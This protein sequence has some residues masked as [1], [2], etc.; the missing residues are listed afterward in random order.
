[1]TLDELNLMFKGIVTTSGGTK[2]HVALD[3][4]YASTACGLEGLSSG[5][6]HCLITNH[7]L[8]LEDLLNDLRGTVTCKSCQKIIEEAV[9]EYLAEN[10]K[11]DTTFEKEEKSMG[12]KDTVYAKNFSV[13]LTG[14]DEFELLIMDEYDCGV[15]F[16]LSPDALQELSAKTYRK[17]HDHYARFKIQEVNQGVQIFPINDNDLAMTIIDRAAERKLDGVNITCGCVI[18]K[19]RKECRYGHPSKCEHGMFAV[20]TDEYV[21]HFLPLIEAYQEER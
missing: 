21:N 12:E 19:R 1:M 15:V 16:K 8:S 13:K 20:I 2:T 3:V 14:R 10:L 7:D 5:G 11:E 9:E 17:I 18:I 4:G 6:M